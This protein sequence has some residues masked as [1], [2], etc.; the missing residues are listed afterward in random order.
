M[1]N[2]L[3]L[4]TILSL[5]SIPLC[6][7][8]VS[9]PLEQGNELSFPKL[10]FH[11]FSKSK[12]LKL[13]LGTKKLTMKPFNSFQKNIGM[14]KGPNKILSKDSVAQDI[15]LKTLQPGLVYNMPVITPQKR[16]YMPTVDPT[17]PLVHHHILRK[18]IHSSLLDQE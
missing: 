8:G 15:V 14:Y 12:N 18:K 5:F 4:F 11:S 13:K 10:K 7:Q 2:I 6:A 9:N 1:K 3:I 16:L 17:D